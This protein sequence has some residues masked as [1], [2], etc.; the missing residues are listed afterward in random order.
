MLTMTRSLI[1][2]SAILILGLVNAACSGGAG[3]TAGGPWQSIP[4]NS[5]VSG[6]TESA[7]TSTAGHQ[8]VA[9]V[10]WRPYDATAD[11]AVSS[12]YGDMGTPP[13]KFVV[14]Q[15]SLSVDGTP[16]TIPPAAYRGY[17]SQGTPT[18]HSLKFFQ[19]GSTYRLVIHLGDGGES[20]AGYFDVVPGSD[21]LKARGTEDGPS[22]MNEMDGFPM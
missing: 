8:L 12:W 21:G 9:K 18:E 2:L 20:W 6:L 22:L 14:R 4:T 7:T 19:R 17:A 13:P 16:V 10:V 11:A 15:V 5:A 1:S 3:G